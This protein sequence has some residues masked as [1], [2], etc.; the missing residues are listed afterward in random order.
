MHFTVIFHVQGQY[1][2]SSINLLSERVSGGETEA[3]RL[4]V[5]GLLQRPKPESR[6]LPLPDISYQKSLME[7]SLPPSRAQGGPRSPLWGSISG[8]CR[9][10]DLF[11]RN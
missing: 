2:T 3:S 11:L 9:Q 4:K 6:P 7:E 10:G 5:T 8:G 1:R